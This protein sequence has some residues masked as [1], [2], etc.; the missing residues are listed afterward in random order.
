MSLSINVLLKNQ[1][2]WLLLPSIL[3][4]FFSIR[5]AI[6][7]LYLYDN[8]YGGITK[9]QQTWQETPKGSSC[10]RKLGVELYKSLVWVALASLNS[11][12]IQPRAISIKRG[13]LRKDSEQNLGLMLWTIFWKSLT[14]PFTFP[15]PTPFPFSLLW[16]YK[17]TTAKDNLH[18]YLPFPHRCAFRVP[19]QEG[20]QSTLRIRT[21]SL[22]VFDR[23]TVAFFDSGARGTAFLTPAGGIV[24]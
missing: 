15:F 9:E 18:I 13:L 2:L 5:E 10:I 6:L 11:Y 14:L 23:E 8:L 17:K 4:T 7:Q 16:L 21:P 3:W 12:L 22:S 20:P 19:L 24:Q 1:T